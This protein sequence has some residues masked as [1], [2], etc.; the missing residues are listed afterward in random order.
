MALSASTPGH[1]NK[2]GLI[3]NF[4]VSKES[5]LNFLMKTALEKVNVGNL[6]MCKSTSFQKMIQVT[7]LPFAYVM[8][9]WRWAVFQGKYKPDDWMKEWVK[10]TEQ[11]QGILPPTVRYQDDFDPGAK[12]GMI[13]IF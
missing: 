7:F 5:D 4:V 1:L 8:D 13:Y 10:L 2:I 6:S 11:Y 9:S 12:Y 3:P